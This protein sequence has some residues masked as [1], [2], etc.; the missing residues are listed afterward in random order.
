MKSSEFLWHFIPEGGLEDF[1][2]DWLWG[3]IFFYYFMHSNNLTSLPLPTSPFR[4]HFLP[5]NTSSITF[6]GSNNSFSIP[7]V[8]IFWV[9]SDYQ[10]SIFL[11]GWFL[12]ESVCLINF[13]IE[14]FRLQ[15]NL[16]LLCNNS[17]RQCS[18]VYFESRSLRVWVF[19]QAPLHLQ[20]KN[21]DQFT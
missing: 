21:L 3:F 10:V 15:S 14:N 11:L 6:W 17:T 18:T 13:Q 20:G 5:C 8:I 1:P 16:I 9:L 7:K 2:T 4:A 19:V 12:E